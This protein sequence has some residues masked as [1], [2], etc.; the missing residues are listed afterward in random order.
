MLYVMFRACLP[1]VVFNVV[2]ASV[3]LNVSFF[4]LSAYSFLNNSTSFYNTSYSFSID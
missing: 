1:D 4:N 2:F 3:Y